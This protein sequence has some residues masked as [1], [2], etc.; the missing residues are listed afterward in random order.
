MTF[1]KLM[2]IPLST[3]HI[4]QSNTTNMLQPSDVTFYRNIVGALQYLTTTRPVL[5]FL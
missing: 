5:N 3:S 1:C 4:F 2:S